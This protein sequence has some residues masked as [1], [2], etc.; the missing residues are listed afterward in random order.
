MSLIA[1]QAGV[2]AHLLRRDP[3]AAERALEVIAETSRTAL[4]QTR[5]VV[6]LL[7]T[8][9]D[10]QPSLPGLVSLEALVR[11]V[12]EAGVD[13]GVTVEG[14][15]REVPA[16]VDLEAYRV[17]QEALTNAVEHAPHQPVT[18]RITYTRPALHVEVRAT[19]AAGPAGA[20]PSAAG[21]GLLGLRER[22]RAVGGRL[23]AGPTADG[24]FR[25]S[26]DLPTGDPA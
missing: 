25:V 16:M 3:A 10:G 18:V 5:S 1:V 24:G 11:G 26:A 6:G 7:R 19:G 2:G 17:V 13:V 22:A 21:F 23:V 14:P 15:R 4:T 20:R 12:R 8:D 9:D